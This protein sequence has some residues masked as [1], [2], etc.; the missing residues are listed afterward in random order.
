MLENSL[1]LI[2]VGIG[3][4]FY[5]INFF[6]CYS[7]SKQPQFK[8]KSVLVGILSLIVTITLYEL[9]INTFTLSIVNSVV[10]LI[11]SV[12]LSISIIGLEILLTIK[13]LKS[14]Q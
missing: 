5:L 7:F 2:M 1:S 8:S 10:G 4:T 14:N 12:L 9:V 6:L 3:A 11:I 13:T